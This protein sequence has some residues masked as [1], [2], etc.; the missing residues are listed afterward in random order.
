MSLKEAEAESILQK[1]SYN[2]SLDSHFS[3]ILAGFYYYTDTFLLTNA[4][5]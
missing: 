5:K 1:E 2:Q 4:N 3:Y